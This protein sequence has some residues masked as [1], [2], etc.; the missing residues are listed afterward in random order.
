VNEASAT[1]SAISTSGFFPWIELGDIRIQSYF[2]FISLV[3]C[4]CAVWIPKRAEARG[5]VPSRAIDIFIAAMA[6]GFFGARLLHIF[7]EEPRY[8]IENPTLVFD[9]MSG[10]FVWYGGF[11]GAALTIFIFLRLRKDRTLLDWLDFF[12]PV[13]AIGYAGG[14]LACV[15]T[16]CCFGRVCD[17]HG[18]LYRFPTQGFA[19]LWE[20]S[21]GLFLLWLE[22]NNAFFNRFTGKQKLL[23]GGLFAVWLVLHGAGRMIMESL[24]ADPRGPIYGMFT[25]SMAIS[26]VVLLAGFVTLVRQYIRTKI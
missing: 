24:R 10:G 23:S 11:I 19:V 21:A 20:L 3:L 15:L 8:Y 18:S 13:A 2:F 17:W 26:L 16:G 7:W 22:K 1:A 4:L 6:G 9:V 12:A 25:I 5:L 14:R